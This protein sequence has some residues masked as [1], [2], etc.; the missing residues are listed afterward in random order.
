MTKTA[1]DLMDEY[2]PKGN[3]DRGK[4]LAIY[5]LSKVEEKYHS[6]ENVSSY[7]SQVGSPDTLGK[8]GK[9]IKELDR[10]NKSELK[11]AGINMTCACGKCVGMING[12]ELL[13]RLGIKC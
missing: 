3:K 9:M 13:R 4:V 6:Q 5:S 12:Q 8:V 1:E 11:K 10:K 7:Q 2:F